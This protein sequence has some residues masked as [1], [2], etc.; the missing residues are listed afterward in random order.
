MK[1]IFYF[2]CVWYIKKWKPSFPSILFCYL[3]LPTTDE[4][5][6]RADTDAYNAGEDAGTSP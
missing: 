5:F 4:H 6:Y 1:A 2:F 3:E